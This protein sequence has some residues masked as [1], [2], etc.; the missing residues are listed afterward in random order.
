MLPY[1]GGAN[2]GF[3]FRL[4]LDY[5]PTKSRLAMEWCRIIQLDSVNY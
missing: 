5:W 3:R 4:L 1:H 2:E